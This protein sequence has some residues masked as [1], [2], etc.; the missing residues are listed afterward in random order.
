MAT[1]P[2]P[3]D[4]KGPNVFIAWS[5]MRSKLIAEALHGWLPMVVQT[6]RPYASFEMD[7]GSH[8]PTVIMG[9]LAS[10]VTSVVCVTPE[11]Q[12]DRWI[13]FEAGAIANNV[14][15]ANK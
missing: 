5:G 15:N 3:T 8:W 6:V 4:D 12:D 11:N 9:N 7:K 10:C 2:Q 13:N 1:K 14:K